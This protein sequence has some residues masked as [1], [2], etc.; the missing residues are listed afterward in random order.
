MN[1][2]LRRLLAVITALIVVFALLYS[3]AY[4]AFNAEHNCSGDECSVCLIIN[5]CENTVKLLSAVIAVFL[6]CTVIL[7]FLFVLLRCVLLNTCKSTLVNLKVKLS[8]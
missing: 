5:L 4:P 3:V 1:N 6:L 8:N 7:R 2:F